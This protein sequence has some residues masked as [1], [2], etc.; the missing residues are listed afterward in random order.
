MLGRYFLLLVFGVADVA[1]AQEVATSQNMVLPQDATPSSISLPGQALIEGTLPGLAGGINVPSVQQCVAKIHANCDALPT[2]EQKDLCTQ[3]LLQANDALCAQTQLLYQKY[4]MLPNKVQ[5]FGPVIVFTLLHIGDGQESF[6]MI[7]QNGNLIGL[8]DDQNPV[9]SQNTNFLTVQK[10]NPGAGMLP[11]I[12]GKAS[13]VPQV[14][15]PTALGNKKG[16]SDKMQL[17]FPQMINV[18]PCMACQT[19]AVA[20]IAY[21]FSY[22]AGNFLGIKWLKMEPVPKVKPDVVDQD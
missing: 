6:H 4:G 10:I 14:V 1:F 8:A 3:Q 20:D 12:S 18:P 11:A 21:L 17:I 16:E 22:P 13:E 2:W 19:V 9:I 15:M 5:A 7:D